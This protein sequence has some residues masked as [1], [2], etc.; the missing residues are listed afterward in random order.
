[1]WCSATP[2]GKGIHINCHW[3][4]QGFRAALER[5]YF[6]SLV[7][8]KCNFFT[9]AREWFVVMQI[10]FSTGLELG[11]L[12]CRHVCVSENALFTGSGLRGAENT[13]ATRVA[14]SS[15]FRTFHLHVW[16]S[17]LRTA[18]FCKSGHL[19]YT[20]TS[21]KFSRFCWISYR[22]PI[23]STDLVKNEGFQI[24]CKENHC[25]FEEDST[26]LRKSIGNLLTDSGIPSEH[27]GIESWEYDLEL[28]DCA[29]W[30]ERAMGVEALSDEA[31]NEVS[32]NLA[33]LTNWSL[34]PMPWKCWFI[35]P[36][37]FLQFYTEL[38]IT[39]C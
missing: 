9:D 24:F 20:S 33:S 10:A 13:R 11:P 6:R 17:S 32:Q 23:F 37:A 25:W 21:L 34:L 19:Q 35:I 5:E 4:T 2:S 36:V 7:L 38:S 12:V 30:E 22:F 3:V 18:S 28:W 26:I 15:C 14:L 16:H 27:F 29:R 39:P 8:G 31:E 1:M